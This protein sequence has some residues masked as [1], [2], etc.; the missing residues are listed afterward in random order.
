MALP[1]YRPQLAT[2][3]EKPPTGPEWLHELKYDGYRIGCLVEK[4]KAKLLSRRELDWTDQFPQVRD[5]AAQLPLTSAMLD[6]EVAIV[7]PDGRTSFQALQN[8]FSRAERRGATYFVF[9]LLHLDGQDLSQLPLEQRKAQLKAVLE[10][11]ANPVLRYS[12]HFDVDG[13]DFFRSACELGAEGIV[14]KRRDAKYSPTRADTWLKTKCVQRQ[15]FVIGGF[16][17]P[18]GS[19][20]GIGALLLGYYDADGRLV[21]AGKVGTGKG[22]TALYL[23]EMRRGLNSIVQ[24]EC[25]YA[26]QPPA[27]IA[28]L[29]KWVRPLLVGEVSFTE[30]TSD[31]VVRHPSFQGFRQDKRAKDVTRDYGGYSKS[32][33]RSWTRESTE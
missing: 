26:K 21:F 24:A 5:A 6:G 20:V 29:A 31:G 32:T 7:M 25:P 17:E 14:S 11:A 3:V 16:T 22:F 27:A 8:H 33:N 12:E 13:P 4:A 30:W 1:R 28:R 19:R 18:E 23:T 9:D 2:L 10:R 15:E